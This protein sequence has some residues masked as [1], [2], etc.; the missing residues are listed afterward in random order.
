M[1][2]FFTNDLHDEFAG[3]MLG[4]TATGG[5]DVGVLQAVGAA[6]GDGDDGAHNAAWVAA[7]D[8]ML[9]EAA[10]TRR[11]ESRCRL[12]FWASAC[13]ATSYH[14]LYGARVD[15]RLLAA[16]RKQIA[17]FEAGL[18]LL[19]HPVAPLRVPFEGTT[20][21]GYL[22]PVAGGEAETRPLVILTNGYD[23]T[24]TEMYF[25]TAVAVARRG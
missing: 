10:A 21:P 22:L 12:T 8:R 9:A 20:M 4:Y 16:F 6:V 14:P 15:P 7:G 17:A 5:P 25:A 18:A 24:V 19:P 23:A 3:W 2:R 11:Q 13:Y 1:G